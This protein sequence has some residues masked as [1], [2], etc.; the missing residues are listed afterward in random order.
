MSARIHEEREER[1]VCA[2][3]CAVCPMTMKVLRDQVWPENLGDNADVDLLSG[4][5]Q[6][7]RD[8]GYLSVNTAASSHLSPSNPDR[9]PEHP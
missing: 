9:H 6:G 5:N 3:W 4:G 7:H 1:E 8:G 2:Q